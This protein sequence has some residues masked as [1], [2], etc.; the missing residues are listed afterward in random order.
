MFQHPGQDASVAS[1]SSCGVRRS[2]NDGGSPGANRPL[3]SIRAP[4]AHPSPGTSSRE[5]LAAALMSI[6]CRRSLTIGAAVAHTEEPR[7]LSACLPA[8]C[9]PRRVA[10]LVL[11][12][13]SPRDA[14]DDRHRMLVP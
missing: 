6:A 2:G 10:R 9:R 11:A 5:H 3:A 12:I 4:R 14:D 8:A 13:L 7:R 1:R